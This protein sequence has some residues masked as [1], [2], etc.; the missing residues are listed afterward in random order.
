MKNKIQVF[1]AA[2]FVLVA[3]M[4]SVKA[5][6]ISNNT[7]QEIQLTKSDTFNDIRSR[8]MENFDLTNVDYKQGVVNSVVKFDIAKN[9]KIVNVHSNGECKSVSKEIETVLSELD[10][11]VDRKK[12]NENMVAYTYV[13]PVTVEINNK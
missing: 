2:V 13:M 10:Y 11:K 6:T 7:I 9:G 3:V 8:L 5:Q 4:N 12:L 1:V